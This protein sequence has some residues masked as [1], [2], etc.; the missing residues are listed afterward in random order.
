MRSRGILAVLAAVV[1]GCVP[2]AAAAKDKR[3]KHDKDGKAD[4]E[5]TGRVGAGED[6]T[7]PASPY[8]V[9][10]RAN[11]RPYEV[12]YLT[13][14]RE[15]RYRFVARFRYRSAVKGFAARLN[16]R[17]IE[18]LR[19]DP[20]ID[21]IVPDAEF[22][23]DGTQAL[24]AGEQAPAGVRRIGAAPTG[25]AST[26]AS[27]PVAVLDTGIDLANAD[28]NAKHGVNCISSTAAANDDNGHGTHVAGTIGARNVG[29]DIVGVAPGTLVYSV[30]I[31]NGK[32]AGSL[33]QLLCGVDWVTRNAAVLGIRTANMSFSGSGTDDGNCGYSNNDALHRAICGAAAAGVTFV[34]SAGNS[35][36]SFGSVAPASYREVLTVTGMSDADG[37][38]G[39]LGTSF[40]GCKTSEKD[41]RYG[42][43]S[44]FAVSA[45]DAAHVISAPGTCVVSS[46][47]GGGTMLYTGT[48]QAA[49][50]VAGAVAAC[51]SVGAPCAG[52][53]PSA[54][55]ARMRELAVAAGPGNG[56]VGDPLAPISGRTYGHLVS[57][58]F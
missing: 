58:R 27:A 44:N 29:R 5:M 23:G 34:A 9:L 11:P 46:R 2:S 57:A 42:A 43:Y 3:D 8:V 40:A 33:S 26:A 39:A 19:A 24:A 45:A 54:V 16:E 56:F 52:L 41:D 15:W 47:R 22:V 6:R 55:I 36:R 49:P 53:A 7:S 28:L 51:V 10:Y 14:V 4:S 30:K 17:Q 1:L 13:R 25:L 20:A 12:E 18:K 38:P 48:S 31:L 37:K 21:A 35:A 50:H 32:M